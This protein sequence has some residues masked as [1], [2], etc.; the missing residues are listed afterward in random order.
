MERVGIRTLFIVM[1]LLLGFATA[2]GAGAVPAA[3]P[4][5]T[6]APTGMVVENVYW[7]PPEPYNGQTY[8]VIEGLLPDGCTEIKGIT[9]PTKRIP[10]RSR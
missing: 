2:C 6:P 3:V 8:V 5:E 10:P 1:A 4:T 9:I 7:S